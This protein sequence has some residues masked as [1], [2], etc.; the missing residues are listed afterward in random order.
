[1]GIPGRSALF[2]FGRGWVRRESWGEGSREEKLG[3]VREG[4]LQ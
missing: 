3:G 2:F 1:M 4:K